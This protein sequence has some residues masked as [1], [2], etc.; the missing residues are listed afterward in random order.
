MKLD[1]WEIGTAYHYLSEYRRRG[2]PTRSSFTALYER[3]HR[4]V[5]V[6]EVSPTRQENR[7]DSSALEHVELI[8]TRL[9]AEILG[10]SVRR[11]Q[12]HAADLDAVT[13]GT[14][15]VFHADTVRQYRDATQGGA[16]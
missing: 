13:V 10:W 14:R 5:T 7:T 1:G 9:A 4:V 3:L 12:R 15:L 16:Q 2:L 8:G 6:G 11:V